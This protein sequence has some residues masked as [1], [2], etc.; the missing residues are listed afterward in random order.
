MDRNT[1]TGLILIFVIMLAWFYFMAP[2]QEELQRRQ[3]EQARQDS[4]AAAQADT[5]QPSTQTPAKPQPPKQ[6]TMEEEP[7][8]SSPIP[9]PF[10]RAQAN[11]T[12]RVTVETPLYRS[13]FTNLGA[14][15]NQ[16]V[17]K[18][19]TR[20]DDSSVQLIKDTVRSAYSLGFL[21][22][23]NMNVETSQILFHQQETTDY[24]RIGE[25]EKKSLTYRLELENGQSLTYTYTFY[26]DTYRIDLD[27]DLD[28][29]TEQIAGRSIDLTW[30]P[31]LNLTEKNKSQENQ[32]LSSYVFMGGEMERFKQDEA[33]RSENNYN[34]SVRWVS[35]RN[36]FFTQII[37][38]T[39]PTDGAR[40]TGEVSGQVDQAETEH[41][42]STTI[43]SDIPK[44]RQIGYQLYIGPLQYQ[45]L[46]TYDTYA[47][48]MVNVGFWGIQ[49][50]S[51]PLV[52]YIIIPFFSFASGFLGNYGLVIILF[53][54]AIKGVLYPL[55]K[56]SFKSMAAMRE[57]QP[58]LKEIQEKYKD[59]PQKQQKETMKLYKKA[60]VN[61]L[62]GCLP[63]LLQFP[64][65]VTLYRFFQN[66]ILIRQKPFLWVDDLSAPDMLIDL[67]FSIPFLGDY[68]GG[69]V[70]LM[71][72][73]MAVQTQ[74][75]GGATGGG[76][77]A[78]GPS[79]KSFQYILPFILLF[80]FNNFAAG[81]SLYYL[82]YNA[83][84]ILQQFWINKQIDKE[85]VHEQVATSN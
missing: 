36:K 66:S 13:K 40:L 78:G 49:W 3:A 72:A 84:S 38:P 81:L 79:M 42:Y 20:W 25:D 23:D 27:I 85:K 43:R 11:D 26:G 61:P 6:Q 30:N 69:F 75:T 56:K 14:G 24:L 63:M 18:E 5:G 64:V 31:P 53:A 74:M 12:N 8:D 17:L 29:L 82:F 34:G 83:L 52:R 4:I 68:L 44:D 55:T 77:G 37:K 57:L 2:S 16:F 59:N 9:E 28:E 33:G 80:V 65:L 15:P 45:E 60:D 62:G 46:K 19:F 71:S 7:D 48:D 51:D 76:G 10:A 70:V 67:P 32:S 35:S 54:V 73:S 50:F 21:T 41:H 58:E 1:V 22:R 47:Y 39:T